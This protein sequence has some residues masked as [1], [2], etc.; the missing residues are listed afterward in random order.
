[1]QAPGFPHVALRCAPRNDKE[2]Q[3]VQKKSFFHQLFRSIIFSPLYL[4][5]GLEKVTA[6]NK[7]LCKCVNCT[8]G[9]AVLVHEAVRHVLSEDHTMRRG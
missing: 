9:G 8:F 3:L 2:I 6:E 1:M 5:V 4:L 7:N